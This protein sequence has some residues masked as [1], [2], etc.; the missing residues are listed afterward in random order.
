MDERTDRLNKELLALLR[1]HLDEA[2]LAFDGQ[3]TKLTGGFW[4]ELLS[5][6]VKPAPDDWNRALVA[7][8]M[9]DAGIAAKEGAF[10]LETAS[11]GYPTPMVR[12]QRGP[13]AG[14]DGRAVMVMD[15]AD[16][17][18]LLAGLDG[19]AAIVKLPSLARRLPVVLAD[20][21][22][23]LHRLDAGPLVQRLAAGD[24]PRPDV[25]GILRSLRSTAE[26]L[27]RPA[28]AAC[29]AWLADHRPATDS[30]VICHGDLHPFNVLV[31]DGDELTVLD[32]S[33]AVIAPRAY[34]VG[35]TSLML[36]EP[37][38][39]V[40]PF[41]RPVIRRVG[42]ALSTRFIRQYEAR[43]GVRVDAD[44]L[45][46]YQGLIC[47]RALTEVAGWAAAGTLVGREGHPWVINEGALIERLAQ[48]TGITVLT[49]PRP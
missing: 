14:I 15:L 31:A 1:E 18:P 38:L 6:K 45:A 48:L 8:V 5:F 30:D 26:V 46:W 11:Q 13:E 10:Q 41:L 27:E 17:A 42:K 37:P 36:A 34:D 40:P 49:E 22:A 3:P 7:R 9:P 28:L 20:V 32:W 2:D 23:Q 33:A 12:L 44:V 35:F 25:D 39:M 47:V 4:A 21:L 29:T 43:A 16:G 19:V 24:A